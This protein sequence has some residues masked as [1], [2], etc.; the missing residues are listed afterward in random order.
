MKKQIIYNNNF[1]KNKLRNLIEGIINNYG[2]LKAVKI[3][4]KIKSTGLKYS[5]K[6][7]ISLGTEDLII[8]LAKKILIKKTENQIYKQNIRIKIGQINENDFL[9]NIIFKWN[10]VN[11]SLT[12]QIVKTF[13]QTDILNPVYMMIISGARGNLSQIKQIIGF[14]GLISDS[15]GKII[16]SPIKSNLKEGLNIEEYFIS[17]YGARKGIID[18]GLKTANSG[19]LT[20]R[21]IYSAQNIIIKQPD[22]KTRAGSIIKIKQQNKLNYTKSINNLVGRVINENTTLNIFKGQDLCKY[23]AKKLVKYKKYILIRKTTHCKINVGT[24]QLCYGWDLTT[25][26]LAKIGESVGILAAQSI[27]EPGTQ[28]TMRTFHTGGIYKGKEQKIIESPITGKIKYFKKYLKKIKTKFIKGFLLLKEKTIFIKKNNNV[29]KKIILPKYSI[30]LTKNNASIYKNQILIQMPA[31]KEIMTNKK[32]NNY[33]IMTIKTKKDGILLINIIKNY[34][35]IWILFGKVNKNVNLISKKNFPQKF[36]NLLKLKNKRIKT[37]KSK[38]QTFEN[39]V[40]FKTYKKSKI[41]LNEKKE[42]NYLVQNII[43]INKNGKLLT[44]KENNKENFINNKK[45]T[46]MLV[47]K[48]K[49]TLYKGQII[50]QILKNDKKINVIKKGIIYLTNKETKIENKSNY[51]IEK[52]TKIMKIKNFTEKTNDIIEG[53][54]KIE[55]ILEAKKTKN[56][57]TIK[58]NVHDQLKIIYNKYKLKYNNFISAKKA[59]ATIQEKLIKNINKVYSLQNVQIDAKHIEIIVK[60]MTSKVIIIESDNKFLLIGEIIDIN[61]LEKLNETLQNKIK[62]EPIIIGISQIPITSESFISAACF[63][64]T[65]RILIKAA[66]GGK[67]DWLKG[68]KEN[69]IIGKLIPSGTGSSYK[70]NSFSRLN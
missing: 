8:P 13:K 23:L 48:N 37:F 70:H 50:E 3:L 52:N 60:Q 27:G 2:N 62:Y 17:C 15:E 10:T 57:I 59:I 56:S 31:L 44:F 58:N 45:I 47:V 35:I 41:K 66:L 12:K 18:T 9:N 40:N 11:D 49:R 1:D 14:R 24:C 36:L 69:I 46:G 30:L 7:G 29:I 38:H 55:E 5:T 68:L 53:L 4:D 67:I 26:K 22:C 19:Y 32:D 64:E 6:A 21:L 65:T 51:L 34:K 28:L 20:R 61:K 16:K 43:K 54:P 42:T 63:Q 39:L 33:N 25:N